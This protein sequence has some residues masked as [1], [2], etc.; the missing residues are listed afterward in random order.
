MKTLLFVHDHP[1]YIEGDRVYSGGGLPYTVWS[2][3]LI[4]FE[5]I[6]VVGR[7][8]HN[9]LDVI[10][11]T[12][13]VRFHLFDLKNSRD[14]IL[15]LKKIRFELS[16]LIDEA[17]VVLARLPSK[18]GYFASSLSRSKGKF[19]WVEQV[20]N[21]FEALSLHGS[22][23]GTLIAPISQI[24]NK[25]QV[26]KANAVVYVTENTLQNVYP[27]SQH[28]IV[29]SISNVVIHEIMLPSQVNLNRFNVHK[30]RIG[31]LGGF[32]VRY[33]GQDILLQ[34]VYSL[35]KSIQNNILL[36]FAGKGDY[37][38]VENLAN[39]LGLMENIE[40]LGLLSSRESVNTL[41][42]SLALYVQPS[43]TEGLPRS[44][45]EAMSRGCPVV[46]SNAGGIPELLNADFVH[47]SGD[48]KK[49]ASDIQFLY[50]NNSILRQ[51][52]V[53]SLEKAKEFSIDGLQNKRMLFYKQLSGVL[54][55][56]EST[57]GN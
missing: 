5:K 16:S 29:A 53:R 47:F 19:L 10:S 7:R 43:L 40:Y 54:E 41:L 2:N 15:K 32:D 8:S 57:V 4:E 51:E 28:A 12:D 3:Y 24:I 38:W 27:S 46:G 33:K 52:S 14:F 35:P 21:A 55:T 26:K 23:L 31:M 45:I 1:F 37:S 18:L 56:K 22:K 36:S 48:Y 34:A 50:D 17:D 6:I 11:S 20:G 42:D 25:V 30:F 49:L 39:E 44:V 9:K 13:N